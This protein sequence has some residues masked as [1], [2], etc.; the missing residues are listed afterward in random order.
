LYRDK[1][2]TFLIPEKSHRK[3]GAIVGDQPLQFTCFQLKQGDIF[4]CG[5][6]GRDDVIKIQG[7]E[8]VMNYDQE[9][10]LDFVREG[11]GDIHRILNVIKQNYRLTDDISLLSVQIPEAKKS[12]EEVWESVSISS[13]ENTVPYTK[14]ESFLGGE[15]PNPY[16]WKKMGLVYL[17][18]RD[19]LKS[20]L[21]LEKYSEMIPSDSKVIFYCGFLHFKMGN[22]IEAIETAERVRVRDGM[23]WRNLMQLIKF[24][25][26]VGNFIR[27]WSILLQ[28]EKLL[29]E[30]SLP[31][32]V[33]NRI[34]YLR[35]K[36]ELREKKM[37]L[38]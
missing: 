37:K 9:L 6:D 1:I 33:Y 8:E 30:S 20:I 23:D 17:K 13:H 27:A 32:L 21:C 11:E 31:K 38:P 12:P 7:E 16:E 5:S 36:I 15:I 14:W 35:N 29:E 22:F 26:A 3:L 2:A 34:N 10:F 24:Y 25:I 4:I 19:F 18:N 28:L